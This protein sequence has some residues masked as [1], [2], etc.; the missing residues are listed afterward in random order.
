MNGDVSNPQV[1]GVEG[2]LKTYK[3]TTPLLNFWGP[4]H[5]SPF[6]KQINDQLTVIQ[7]DEKQENMKYTILLILTDGTV[8]DNKRVKQQIIRASK[9]PVSIIII[10]IGN[11]PD[12]FEFMRKLDADKEPLVLRHKDGSMLYQTRDCVQFLAC[13]ELKNDPEK[14]TRELLREIPDQITAY[15]DS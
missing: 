6:L 14:I 12:N 3:E 10:G 11:P 1:K 13:N 4:T 5:F 8:C 9:L 15:F 7:K 2:V